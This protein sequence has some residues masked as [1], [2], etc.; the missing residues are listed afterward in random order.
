MMVCWTGG[1]N[2]TEPVPQDWKRIDANGKFTFFV[3]PDMEA[4]AVQGTDSY[5]GKYR[6]HGMQLYFDYGWWPGDLCDARYTEQKPQNTD[7]TTQIKGQRA[8]LI[9]FYEPHPKM[10]HQFPYVT[11]VCFADLGTAEMDQKITLTMWAN[12]EGHAEQQ[13]AAKIFQ[14]IQFSR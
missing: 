1:A 13:I 11:V 3:P 7:V 8:R 12:G 4:E 14:S 9:T 5:V 10:D 2:A 6:G